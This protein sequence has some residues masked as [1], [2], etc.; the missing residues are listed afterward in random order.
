MRYGVF[1][2]YLSAP[3]CHEV[4]PPSCPFHPTP[5]SFS[6]QVFSPQFVLH[7]RPA[8]AK[9]KDPARFLY[10]CMFSPPVKRERIRRAFR[11]N[12]PGPSQTLGLDLSSAPPAHILAGSR[13]GTQ[14]FPHPAAFSRVVLSYKCA[15]AF[16]SP[17][18]WI[19]GAGR[20]Y[21]C[22]SSPFDRAPWSLT[23][24]KTV[25]IS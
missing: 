19:L 17:S 4:T 23:Q 9:R 12:V 7:C 16:C 24:S 2:P 14:F 6:T 8:Q 25:D 15:Q 18:R 10:F 20:L 5:P 11:Q 21:I 3:H 1:L 22:L 13:R